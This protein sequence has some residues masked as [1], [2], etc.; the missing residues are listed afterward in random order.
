MSEVD[1]EGHRVVVWSQVF[2]WAAVADEER[3]DWWDEPVG[4][5]S[6]ADRE[7]RLSVIAQLAHSLTRVRLAAL[8]PGLDPQANLLWMGLPIRARNVFNRERMHTWRDLGDKTLDDVLDWRNMGVGTVDALLEF[9]AAE[10]LAAALREPGLGFEDANEWDASD[11]E[12][13]GGTAI[14]V[15]TKVSAPWSEAVHRAVE[16]LA[17]WNALVGHPNA[18]LLRVS[19]PVGGPD[20]VAG[21]AGRGLLTAAQLLGDDA[22]DIADLLEDQLGLLEPREMVILKERMLADDPVT[23]DQLGQRFDVTR[24]RIR[25]IETRLRSKLLDFVQQ[26][27]ALRTLFAVLDSLVGEV[28]ALEDVLQVMPALGRTLATVNQP[29]WR[30]LD[31]LGDSFEVRGGWCVRRTYEEAVGRTKVRL[32]EAADGNGLVPLTGLRFVQTIDPAR[33]AR[34]DEEWIAACG[35]PIAAGHVLV[36]ARSLGDWGVA[37][38]ALEGEP[39]EAEAIL[40]RIGVERSLGSLRN[41]LAL[42]PRVIRVDRDVFALADWGLEEYGG[43]RQMIKDQVD[44][45]GG[46]VLLTDLLEHAE[47]Y[48]VARSSVIA[49][50]SAHP[51]VCTSGVVQYMPRAAAGNGREPARTKRLFRGDAEWRLR[52]TVTNDH[53]RGSGF[54]IP[55][56]AASL[57]GLQ[58]GQTQLLSAT[59]G[60]QAV[61]W[62]GLQPSL[63]S[64]RARLLEMGVGLG[65]DVFLVLQ[66]DR[67]FDIRRAE[68]PTGRPLLDAARL[69]GSRLQRDSS[70]HEITFHLAQAVQAEGA[71]GMEALRGVYFQRGDEDVAALLLDAQEHQERDTCE[72]TDGSQKELS[73]AVTALNG[74]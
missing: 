2:P 65:E 26:D 55:S 62:T 8:F 44:A 58:P 28:T 41:A 10:S 4:D 31:R 36:R 23:L 49:Y 53:L 1:E 33:Q 59:F 71:L 60:E 73:L 22:V 54:P 3:S 32:E 69:T 74:E 25:Q 38:L 24:E 34:L 37:V 56:A 57:V 18:P 20:V 12:V 67:V 45:G 48:A 27:Q 5:G 30:L 50:A 63:G 14:Q 72:P 17:R 43:I 47:R 29:V 15:P 19:A 68:R 7:A 13:V 39:L 61:R 46:H 9:L 21:V 52:I 64:I 42:E 40:A 6:D 16:P 35:Y 11:P 66:D 51:F 70:D